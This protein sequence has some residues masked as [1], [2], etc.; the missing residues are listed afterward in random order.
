MS[1]HILTLFVFCLCKCISFQCNKYAFQ[2]WW[3][4]NK[5]K[6]IK[7]GAKIKCRYSKAWN[8]KKHK[9]CAER[10]TNMRHRTVKRNTIKQTNV[11]SWCLI[12]NET[13]LSSSTS[14]KCFFP[15]SRFIQNSCTQNIV[16]METKTIIN[17]DNNNEKTSE[18]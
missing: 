14:S 17:V 10:I 7:I 12:L 8:E 2:N 16:W 6:E 4:L 18:C 1:L 15:S 3:D 5:L 9:K 11:P 13:M